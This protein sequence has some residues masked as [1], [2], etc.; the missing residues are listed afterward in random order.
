MKDLLESLNEKGFSYKQSSFSNGTMLIFMVII[1]IIIV[2]VIVDF[3]DEQVYISRRQKVLKEIEGKRLSLALLEASLENLIHSSDFLSIDSYISKRV[4]RRKN[5][6]Y[7][8]RDFGV[9]DFYWKNNWNFV[10]RIKVGF[11]KNGRN[12]KDHIFF[13]DIKQLSDRFSVN[14]IYSD[15]KKSRFMKQA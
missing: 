13:V 11:Y 1:M 14:G 6:T 3:I 9:H 4:R 7:K 8:I 5:E 12:Q 2:K 10:Y 15:Y